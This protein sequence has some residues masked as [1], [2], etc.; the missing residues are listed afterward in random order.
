MLFAMDEDGEIERLL[1][2]PSHKLKITT[3]SIGLDSKYNRYI[4]RWDL[5]D[6]FTEF[7]SKLA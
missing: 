7:Y 3:L 6:R 2:I 1:I 4:D 5:V